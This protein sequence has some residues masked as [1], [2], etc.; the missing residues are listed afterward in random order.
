MVFSTCF[1][2]AE[3]QGSKGCCS[4][5]C[6]C[7][8]PVQADNV[9]VNWTLIERKEKRVDRREEILWVS[10]EPYY[11]LFHRE[12]QRLHPWISSGQALP[13][14]GPLLRLLRDNCLNVF[15]TPTVWL[16]SSLRKHTGSLKLSHILSFICRPCSLGVSW[17][18]PSTESS[19]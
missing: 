4:W 7:P 12:R 2:P 6:L 15:R 17:I 16:K 14:L 9:S 1:P 10:W 8:S 19:S 18:C 3:V 11:G 5:Y 13:Y